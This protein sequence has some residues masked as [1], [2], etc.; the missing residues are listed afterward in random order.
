M[1]LRIQCPNPACGKSGTVGD[2]MAGLPFR[3]PH[4]QTRFTLPGTDTASVSPQ[5]T[6]MPGNPK[7]TDRAKATMQPANLSATSAVAPPAT[8]RNIGRFQ[9]KGLLG[10]GASGAVYRAHDPQLQRDVALKIPHPGSLD[11]PKRVERFFRE[12]R[13]AAQLRHPHIVPVFDAG[14]DAGQHYIASAFI[15]GKT[16]S[17]VARTKAWPVRTIAQGVHWMAR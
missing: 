17:E 3:C 8:P 5:H 7:E 10:T 15:E 2:S 13:A 16:L 12:A 6:V 1:P 11:S 9:V 14:V 4:C